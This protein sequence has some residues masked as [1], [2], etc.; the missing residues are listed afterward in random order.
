MEELDSSNGIIFPFYDE[1]TNVIFLCGKGDSAIRYFEYTPEAPYIHFLSAYSSS[2][3]QRGMGAMPKRGLNIA[4]CEIA[5]FFK[6]LNSGLCEVISFTVPR[7]VNFLIMIIFY[8]I[9]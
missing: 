3:P 5:R 7:K 8:R 2:D 4:A 6:L 1:D 9:I